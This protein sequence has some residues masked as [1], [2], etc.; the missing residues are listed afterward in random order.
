MSILRIPLIA[1]FVAAVCSCGPGPGY[2]V[3]RDA[4]AETSP[5][6]TKVRISLWDQKAW[7][8]DRNDRVLVETDIST[9]VP[10]HETPAGEYKVLE[11]LESKQSNRYG[12]YVRERSGR[13]VAKTWEWDGPPPEGTV[14]RGIAMPYWM[15]V[16]WD[17]VG[18]H[19]GKF[20][21]RKCSSFG[22]IRV[23]KRAQPLIFAKTEV[24]TP[25]SIRRESLQ[26]ELGIR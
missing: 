4:Y 10:G 22:C 17:G 14:R 16:T 25:V 2:K 3:D 21:K 26:A 1:S 13:V 24:G 15:R 20:P 6:D 12:E 8:L 18:M 11:K 5:H 23:H 19:V 9:G 7:L